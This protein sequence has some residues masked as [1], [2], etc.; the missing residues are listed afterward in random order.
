M[1]LRFCVTGILLIV[2]FVPF[3]PAV[4]TDAP[5]LIENSGCVACHAAQEV[6]I[7]PPY[8]AI[9]ARY[10]NQDEQIMQRLAQKIRRGGAGNWGAVPMIPHD[11][12]DQQ[13]ALQIVRWILEQRSE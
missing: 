4:A 11:F 3:E 10:G 12:L 1:S 7:G 9:A 6:R 2:A 5:T 8:V 13:Q